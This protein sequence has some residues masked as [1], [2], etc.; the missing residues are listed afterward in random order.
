MDEKLI[1]GLCSGRYPASRNAVADGVNLCPECAA[2]QTVICRC[3]GNLILRSNAVDGD[4]CECCYEEDYVRCTDCGAIIPYDEAWYLPG[5][6]DMRENPYC[7]GC[8]MN[9][10]HNPIKEYCYKPVP[11]FYG[12]SKRYYGVELEMD[13]GGK[14]E[15]NAETLL[16]I[17]NRDAEHMYIKYD[18]SIEDGFEC[19]THPMTLDYHMR[20]MP[21]RELLDE[22]ISI[23]YLSH[24]A[25][26]CGL[27]V[28]INRSGLGNTYDEQEC[29]IAKILYFYEKFWNEILKFSRRTERQVLQWANRY[30]GGLINPKETLKRAKSAHLGRYT[31]VNLENE[32]TIE[33]RIFRGTLKYSTLAAT[34]QFVD[35]VCDTAVSLTDEELQNLTWL[36]FVQRISA[37]KR[38]LIGYLKSRNL[39]VN[40][41]VCDDG[42]V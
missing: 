20:K 36:D 13:D 22:A 10:R 28:H 31:A 8:Y 6:R 38:E 18:G 1:C 29:T 24:L 30:G 35:A 9:E 23:D 37:E 19:V 26:T 34:L 3:C 7:Y 5:D 39:Y 33:M 2:A 27:H 11:I 16:N 21:W 15:D 17:A 32:N 4:L 25:E 12:K 14:D 41:P 40:N 42:E